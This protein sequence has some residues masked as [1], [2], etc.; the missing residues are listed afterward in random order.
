[1][2][3]ISFAAV[4]EGFFSPLDL[5]ALVKYTVGILGWVFFAGYYVFAG[6]RLN[7]A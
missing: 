7:A 1:M 3:M 5:P 6:R 2:I 4:I